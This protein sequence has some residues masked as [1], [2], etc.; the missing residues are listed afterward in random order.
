MT[1][2]QVIVLIRLIVFSLDLEVSLRVCTYRAYLRSF[3]A[4]YSM[5]AVVAVPYNFRISFEYDTFFDVSQKL[6]VSFF[7]FLFDLS[8]AFKQECDMIETFFSGFLSHT[9][10]HVSPF[11][12]FACSSISQVMYRS[13]TSLKKLLRTNRNMLSFGSRRSMMAKSRTL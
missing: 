9:I 2:P 6:S 7:M 12:I 4:L 10:V 11:V 3:A 5:S 1:D 13:L 8:Y